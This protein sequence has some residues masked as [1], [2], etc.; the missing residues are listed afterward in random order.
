MNQQM[1]L[2][3]TLDSQWRCQFYFSGFWNLQQVYHLSLQVLLFTIYLDFTHLLYSLIMINMEKTRWNITLR[4]TQH[5]C[6]LKTWSR[7]MRHRNEKSFLPR[8]LRCRV[9][10]VQFFP[11]FRILNTDVHLKVLVKFLKYLISKHK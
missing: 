1:C 11:N 7:R 9:Y 10:I 5:I 4:K 8:I 6:I 2:K 3:L